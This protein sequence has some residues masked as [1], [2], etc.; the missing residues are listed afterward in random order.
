[1]SERAW[2]G[3]R[4]NLSSLGGQDRGRVESCGITDLDVL[5]GEMPRE[6]NGPAL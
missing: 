6:S 3:G 5:G 1:M 4:F 2:F